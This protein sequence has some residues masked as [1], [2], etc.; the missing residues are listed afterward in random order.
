MNQITFE[1]LFYPKVV[2]SK[3]PT[4]YKVYDKKALDFF[5]KKYEGRVVRGLAFEGSKI[6]EGTVL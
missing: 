5:I 6:L 3:Y 4:T 1:I 2:G